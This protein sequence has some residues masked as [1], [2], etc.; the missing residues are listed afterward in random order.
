[1]NGSG[2]TVNGPKI[3]RLRENQGYTLTDLAHRTRISKAHLSQVERGIRR[4]SPTVA[5]MIAVVL[6][7][8]VEELR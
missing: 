6:G 1:M 3:R 2:I 7:V 8:Q 5:A 4:P